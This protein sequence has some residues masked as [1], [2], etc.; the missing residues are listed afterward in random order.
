MIEIGQ[1]S[2][3]ALQKTI[4]SMGANTLMIQSGAASS[5]GVTFGAGTILTLTPQ[6]SDEIGRQCPAI[7]DVAPIVRARSQ[8][9]YG[10]HNWVPLQIS[11]TTPAF[12]AV[13]DW[14]EMSEGEMFTDRDVRNWTRC[15]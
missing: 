4:A 14:E 11:G 12:L 8:V 1:G 3:A 15:A 10:N 9:V 6:D 2:K 7:S 13:R 5:G